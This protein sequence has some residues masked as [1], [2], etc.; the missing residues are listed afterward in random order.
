[1]YGR[2]RVGSLLA[3]TAERGQADRRP[4]LRARVPLRPD[5]RSRSTTSSARAT[6]ASP[7]LKAMRD[8]D[9]VGRAPLRD[10]ELRRSADFAARVAARPAATGSSCCRTR[11]RCPSVGDRDELRRRHGFDGPTLV[12]A[13]RLSPQKALDVLRARRSAPA[14]ASR[15]WS[16]ATGRSA[17][18][19]TPSSPSS[20]SATACAS[21]GA[22]PRE[23]R[24]R[25]ASPPPTRWCSRR[26][27]RTSRTARR[28]ARG[29][30]AGDRDRRRRGPRDRHRRRERAARRR[31][32]TPGALAAAIRRF[33]ADGALRERLRGRRRRLGRAT[34]RRSG[35][36]AG[37][38]SSS[39]RRPRDRA[40][41]AAAGRADAL[42]AAAE[43]D[44][45]GPSSTRWR[46]GLDLR[47]L[48]SGVARRAA[49]RRDVRARRARG[50]R[51]SSTARS[52]SSTLPFRTRRELRRSQPDAVLVQGAHET[53]LVLLGR[54]ARPACARRSSSTSTATGA[55]RRGCTA[56]RRGGCSTRSPTAS[57]SRRCAAPTP[58]GRSPTT[59]PGSSAR[60]GVEP[61]A[62]FPAFMDLEPFLEP[63]RAAARAPPRALFV[64]VLEHYKGV[65]GLAEAWRARRRRGCPAR[66]CTSSARGT[67]REVVEQLV[68]DLP[69]RD[70]VDRAL[71]TEGVARA[72]DDATVLVLPSRSR[73]AGPRARRGVLPRPAGGRARASAGSSTSSRDGENGLLVPPQDPAG[74]RRRAR[75]RAHR[76]RRWPSGS[77]AGAA[78]RA[79]RRGSRRRRSS[80]RG[81]RRSSPDY[82]RPMRAD[83][84][85]QS[86]KNGVYRTIGETATGVAPSTATQERTLRVLMYHKVNDIPENP[87]TVPVG[88]FDEQM[89]QLGELGYQPSTSTPCSTTTCTGTPLP[90]K[91][92]ADH[93]RRRL[94]RQPRERG[95]GAAEARLPGRHLRAGR[96][97]RGHAA[98]AARRAPGRARHRQPAARL[99]R[100]RRARGGGVR[101]ESHGIGHR[102]LAE[103]E[104]DEA[105]REI[106][107]S[108]LRLEERLGRPVRAFAYVKGSEAHYRPVHVSAAQAGRLRRRVHVDLAARTARPATR[109]SSAATTSSRTRRGRSSSCSPAR[110][111]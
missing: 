80:R 34:T 38:R 101:V 19:S 20:G 53:W 48:A 111:T 95:A 56:R 88:R 92:R 2:T 9:P 91:A 8:A 41:A 70:R 21:S 67:R 16:P 82:D 94:P 93:L 23:D 76:P 99:G 37:S 77:A 87:V 71:P 47:V 43:R 72:L 17:R 4:R 58:C 68:R 98:A 15:S 97:H 86:L 85:K 13:G 54:V 44:V 65:D 14:T 32:A 28:G 75:P 33:F 45:C 50:G 27:G 84:I 103:L 63:A 102:P 89:A 110:A 18:G 59:R 12:F 55:R 78:R 24:A 11:S 22:Q 105:A 35:S 62:E 64:G 60:Y 39:R 40:A 5:A 7:G 96:L 90:A 10:P 74:A 36:T 52:T 6:P 104:V 51:G 57:P 31:A 83:R 61:A 81:W 100:A 109:S 3:G 26:A 108:K 79:R 69:G 42:P 29:R 1:M 106:A 30:D 107:V 73:G 25:A 46:S 66:R 49:A